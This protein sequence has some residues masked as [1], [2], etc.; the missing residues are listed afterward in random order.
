MTNLRLSFG[1]VRRFLKEDLHLNPYKVHENRV[2]KAVDH[3]KK[4]G[5]VDWFGSRIMVKASHYYQKP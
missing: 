1:S 4:V 2:L 3:A 5:F